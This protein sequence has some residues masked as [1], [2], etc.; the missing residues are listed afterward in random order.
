MPLIISAQALSAAWEQWQE[1]GSKSDSREDQP[2]TDGHSNAQPQ[3]RTQPAPSSRVALKGSASISVNPTAA[4]SRQGL[5][6]RA[7]S[8]QGRPCQDNTHCFKDAE[9]QFCQSGAAT[10]LAKAQHMQVASAH[11]TRKAAVRPALESEQLHQGQCSTSRPSQESQARPQSSFWDDRA[12]EESHTM[13]RKET[14]H[15]AGIADCVV[16]V[17]FSGGWASGVVVHSSGV[18]LTVAHAVRG[19]PEAA[20][21]HGSIHSSSLA[22]AQSLAQDRVPGSL[23][24][25]A[26]SNG[27][28]NTQ[29]R[30]ST[31]LMHTDMTG[32]LLRAAYCTI[33]KLP[34]TSHKLA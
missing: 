4:Q 17:C 23:S 31:H 29:T 24:G 21:S 8:S 18:V 10:A 3:S 12:A 7:L 9:Q 26:Q 16:A 30:S 34:D 19:E 32:M 5:Q 20:S 14:S 11:C 27:T 25:S 2:H 22:G 15:S 1:S 13:C 33:V 28:Y 6:G